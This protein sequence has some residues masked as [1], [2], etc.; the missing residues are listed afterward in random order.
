M[1]NIKRVCLL[2]LWHCNF[3][4]IWAF[5]CNSLLQRVFLTYIV[6][7]RAS[8]INNG[9]RKLSTHVSSYMI[10]EYGKYVYKECAI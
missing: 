1:Y 4:H 6:W 2:Y 10:E 8:A 9:N 3:V 5:G 7:E